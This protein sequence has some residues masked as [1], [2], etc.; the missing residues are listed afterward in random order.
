[1]VETAR[2]T[3]GLTD[4][5][6]E[7]NGYRRQYYR[8]IAFYLNASCAHSQIASDHRN[9]TNVLRWHCQHQPATMHRQRLLHVT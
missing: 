1:M 4:R 9:I 2:Q 7:T 8:Y 6:T 5:L 3:D